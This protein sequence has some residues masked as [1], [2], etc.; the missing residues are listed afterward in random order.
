MDRHPCSPRRPVRA[1]I[2]PRVVALAGAALLEA[3]GG[4]G[5]GGGAGLTATA[6]LPISAP[7]AAEDSEFQRNAASYELIGAD[8]AHD[9]K[10]TGAGVL[11]GIVDDGLAP[12]NPEFDGRISKL[13]KDF[14]YDSRQNPTTH[15]VERLARNS[16]IG[17]DSQHG[18]KVASILAAAHNDTGVVGVAPDATIVVLRADVANVDT[19]TTTYT[20]ETVS[21]AIRYAGGAGVQIL[22]ISLATAGRSDDVVAAT[23]AFAHSGGL[24]IWAAGNV[25]A[26]EP[27]TSANITSVNRPSWI[28][29]GGVVPSS[30]QMHY[31][32]NRAG[33]MADRFLVA[34]M[35]V[36]ALA[37]DGTV[38]Q[39]TGTS[40]AAPQVAGAA[41]LLLGRWPQLTGKQAGDILLASARDVGA[42][43][44]DPV[45][46]H[47]LLDI[48]AALK[49]AK[50]SFGDGTT[51]TTVD[52]IGLVLPEGFGA[53]EL[54]AALTSV[55]VLDAFGR[56]YTAS[57]S[58]LVT[59]ART[60]ARRM[61]GSLAGLSR[62]SEVAAGDLAAI[63]Q[64]RSAPRQSARPGEQWALSSAA[65]G[66]RAGALAWQARFGPAAEP[67]GSAAAAYSPLADKQVRVG[68]PIGQPML[69]AAA[70][71]GGNA[72]SAS[73]GLS[74][75][76]TTVRIGAASETGTL[77]GAPSRGP[78]R[79]A[80]RTR[81]GFIEADYSAPLIGAWTWRFSGSL[82]VSRID[83]PAG[84]IF[85]S[86]SPL[87]TSQTAID[88]EGP[89]GRRTDLRL[90]FVQPTT[91]ERGW[92][93]VV[94]PSG[95]D[96]ASRA[97]RTEERRIG[98][99]A[100]QRPF[101]LAAM[102]SSRLVGGSPLTV[103]V[104]HSFGGGT[105]ASL[106]ASV[107]FE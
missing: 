81:T 67:P 47:G 17:P 10:R 8:A 32:S 46:G 27:D 39:V 51:Q 69:L 5:G 104:A 36:S 76:S 38:G 20:N 63:V 48:E 97:L 28:S 62:T 23:E 6:P 1:G 11:V 83:V 49:P 7:P 77:F 87:L 91:V 90:S 68:L 19:H 42:P 14:G 60:A 100:D 50:P 37:A 30:G 3:C 80:R 89:I 73:L 74:S 56:D 78:L 41:A 40:F 58:A 29:V 84:S 12:S 85:R 66:G 65:V 102:L 71:M 53:T 52:K 105:S 59:P 43:G 25:G 18:T 55:T 2:A 35:I 106:N 34:S 61:A 75:A 64:M 31:L 99:A 22:N 95:Y 24:M 26:S 54:K 92:G 33:A 82:G 4:G 86:V 79:L 101:M 94:L 21:S 44:V 88:L 96:L 16:L 98:L 15:V 9:A 93:H 103:G 107:A 70:A 57:L 72:R 45:Y 13:S